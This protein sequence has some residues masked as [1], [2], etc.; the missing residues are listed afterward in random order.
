V[1]CRLMF[2]FLTFLFWSLCVLSFD[3]RF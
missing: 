3:L 1:F 2:V